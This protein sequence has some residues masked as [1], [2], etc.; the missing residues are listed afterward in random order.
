MWEVKKEPKIP[1]YQSIMKLITANIQN[2]LLLPGEK[3]PPERKLAAILGVNRST[4][5]KALDEL[6]AKGVLIRK[7]GSGTIVNDDKWGLMNEPIVDWHELIHVNQSDETSRFVAKVKEKLESGESENKDKNE[8]KGGGRNEDKN[9]N[10]SGGKNER[11][12]EGQK[13]GLLREVLA[14]GVCDSGNGNEKL[15]IDAYTGELPI[16]LVPSFELPK[17]NWKDFIEVMLRK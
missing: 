4:I 12:S 16:E 2:G 5:V 14:E 6:A 1:I 15:L 11:N 7:Q 9:G 3:L 17:I 8:D 13:N 10:K